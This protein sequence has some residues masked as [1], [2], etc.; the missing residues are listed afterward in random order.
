M[1]LRLAQMY[2]H[3]QKMKLKNAASTQPGLLPMAEQAPQCLKQ[4]QGAWEKSETPDNEE[5]L[6]E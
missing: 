2:I 3:F 6:S 1:L 5:S 4:S